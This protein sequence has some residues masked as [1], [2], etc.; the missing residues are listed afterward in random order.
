MEYTNQQNREI[1]E[2]FTLE[3]IPDLD[4]VVLAAL[5][6]FQ[7]ETVPQIPLSLYKRPLVVGSGNGEATGRIIFEQT[8]AI[9]ASES[10]YE[11]KLK[12]ISAIDGVVLISASG[13]KHAPIIARRAKALGKHV[14]LI[15]T[16]NGSEAS[17]EI[18]TLQGDSEYI[19]PKNREPYTYNT[20]SYMGIILGHTQEDPARIYKYI[21]DT[22]DTIDFS[23][24]A[25]YDKYYCI[26]P[27]EFSGVIRMVQVKFI[28]LFGRNIA[29]DVETSEYVK[30]ATTVVPSKELF[31][32][33]GY[34]NTS[35]GK[36]DARINVPLPD[37]AGYA[38]M[39]A[40]AYY[41]IGK[42]QKKHQPYFKQHIE[43]YTKEISK[44]FGEEITWVVG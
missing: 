29:H 5:E 38:T 40:I 22:V 42:I 26:V 31:L 21:Q 39:M 13:G 35:W 25:S 23:K 37:W 9:F 33:F 32:S 34:E 43:K 7:K 12:N 2:A 10:N 19:F 28:E 18:N 4:V 36:E 20:S 16:T 30:H 15:T 24:L 27:K 11:S 1:L 41:V 8:D 17:K 3:T 14:T 44:V 6:L